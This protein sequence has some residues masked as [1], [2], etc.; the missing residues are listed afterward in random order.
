MHISLNGIRESRGRGP[1]LS[2][3]SNCSTSIIISFF[4][5]FELLEDAAMKSAHVD[6]SSSGKSDRL[7]WGTARYHTQF[8]PSAAFQLELQWFVATG[9]VLGE[10]VSGWARKAINNGFHL[11]PVPVDPFALPFTPNS[12][13]LRGPIY[14]PLG[15]ECLSDTGR[16]SSCLCLVALNKVSCVNGQCPHLKVLT[17]AKIH[18][19]SCSTEFYSGFVTFYLISCL[20]F[21]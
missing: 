5:I 2:N 13:P 16:P 3:L 15:V 17:Q 4:I 9:C 7:E 10:I 6:V 11:L 1:N 18:S 8:H 14:V 20:L 19:C 12:D 21:W